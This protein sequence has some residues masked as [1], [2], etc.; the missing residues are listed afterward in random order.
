MRRFLC[1]SLSVALALLSVIGV[2]VLV[3]SASAADSSSDVTVSGDGPFSDLKVTVSQTHNLVNQVVKVSWKGG[4]PTVSDTTYAANYLQIMQCW[5]D[6]RGGP[7]P[8]QCQFGGSSALG[9]GAGS[10][11]AG[12]YTNT[13]QLSY[14]GLKDPAQ[15]LPP[16]SGTGISYV[17]FR[18]VT[19]D[20]ITKG[21]WNEFYDVNTSN[22]VPYARTGP[23]G[24]G[25]VY[26]EAQTGLEAPGLGCGEV[27]AGA[28]GAT[29]GRKCWLVVVPRGE[30]EVDATPYTARSSGLLESSPL[31]ASNWKHRLVVPLGFEPMGRFCPIG[32]DERGTLG[33]EI[34]AEV[35]TRWQPALCQSGG[36]TI[37]GYAQVTDDTARAKLVSGSP[38]MVFLGRP[39]T[40]DQVP[41]G[42]RP[43]YAPVAL[44]GLTLGFF[45]ESQAAFNAPAAVKA[46]DGARLTSLDLTPRLVAKLLTESYQDG[47][48]RLAPS[49]EANPFNLGT[50]PEF[51]KYNPGYKDLSFGG[52]LGD[53]LVPEALADAT[54]ELWNW[55]RQDPAAREFL[56]GTA[57]NAG[58]YGDAAFSG[59]KV[60]PHYKDMELPR[61]E[62][63]KS[64]PFCQQFQD[65][66][67]HP[68]CIQDKH[69]F[70]TDLH[71][72]ARAAAR[73]DTL[74]RTNWDN[75]ATPP[76][77]KKNPPQPAGKRA[78]LALTDTA[79]AARYGLVTARL[80]NAAGRFVSPDTRGLLAGQAAMK[81]SGV[82]G[83]VIADP[84]TRSRDAYPL[85][86]MTYAAT[87]PEKLTAQEGQDYAALLKYA[88]GDGQR[89]GVAAGTLPEGYAPLPADVRGRTRA[90]AEAIAAR[91]GAPAPG[92][93]TGGSAAG[94]GSVGG[95]GTGAGG[96]GDAGGLLAGGSDGTALSGGAGAS[97]GQAGAGDAGGTGASPSAAA[98]GAAPSG[99]PSTAPAAASASDSPLLRTPDWALGAVRYAL[100][101]ALVT[102]LAAAVCGPLLPRAVPRL[103]AVV[104]DRRARDKSSTGQGR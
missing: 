51:L 1:T 54:W 98:S 44:S 43:V 93:T 26:F 24:T 30:S 81:A 14:G 46:R 72:A 18:S 16:A 73:G 71:A 55:V 90:A 102:G 64:D 83:V 25:E 50:D 62:F 60:N 31:S 17:P 19:G 57:D 20:V 53:A 48:S 40:D 5:G 63:P 77:Y 69:P 42:Q 41:A 6:E 56:S 45:I 36:K 21:N 76:G 96:S 88:A 92:T 67:D 52:S 101:I 37:Y 59:M 104:A 89:P 2:G 84:A 68:L 13:R 49:T 91:A 66:P 99:S 23:D 74:A 22:E 85:T 97:A 86:L 79:T 95:S 100:L 9:A 80:Q 34:V 58:R 8:E 33:N 61:E 87:V 75:T 38:G 15:E 70:A 7:D 32:A 28:S 78:V 3:Q 39:A 65:H 12:A 4:A 103:A 94:G 82:S 35:V 11:A 47:N 27:P 29:A 10:Q